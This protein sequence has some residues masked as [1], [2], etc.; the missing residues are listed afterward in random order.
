MSKEIEH[1]KCLYDYLPSDTRRLICVHNSEHRMLVLDFWRVA[2]LMEML[3]SGH[4]TGLAKKEAED[5][6]D[7]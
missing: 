1:E 5:L 4:L 7:F 3:K 2:R 6:I